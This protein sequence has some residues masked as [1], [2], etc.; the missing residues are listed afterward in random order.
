MMEQEVHLN[1]L[2]FYQQMH[3]GIFYSYLRLKEQEIRNIIWMA[4]C[5][6]QNKKHRIP[7]NLVYIFDVAV[8]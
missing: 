8:Q 4:E 7:Q 2:A 6:K 3:Y 1:E 5:I